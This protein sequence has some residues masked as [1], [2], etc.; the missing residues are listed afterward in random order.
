MITISL[1][2]QKAGVGKSTLAW[3][4]VNAALAQSDATTVVLIE[5]DPEGASVGY[6][7]RAIRKYPLLADRF[8]CFTCPDED[9]LRTCLEEAKAGTADYVI[10][11]TAGRLEG[12]TRFAMAGAD[13]V[14]I[15]FRPCIMEYESQM[16]TVRLY[17]ELRMAL[18]A[19]GGTAPTA[20]LLL[21]DW[22]QSTRANSSQKVALKSLYGEELLAGFFVPRRNGYETLDQ[23]II[24]SEELLDNPLIDNIFIRKALEGDLQTARMTLRRIETLR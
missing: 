21:N 24:F 19:N 20:A 22:A 8:L 4:L 14:I 2:G 11:D 9:A 3:L 17:K 5:T 1:A 16:A 18:E 6:H 23:G 13:R 12:L 10:I 15:P 7:R